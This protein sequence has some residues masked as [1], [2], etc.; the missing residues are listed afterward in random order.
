MRYIYIILLS[1]TLS[2]AIAAVKFGSVSGAF[3]S[4]TNENSAFALGLFI[5]LIA[6]SMELV[7][8]WAS[9]SPFL[10]VH[11]VTKHIEVIVDPDPGG[12]SYIMSNEGKVA[13][14]LFLNFLAFILIFWV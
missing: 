7:D 9:I 1:G 2:F 10:P 14:Y 6:T 4:L 11:L 8:I 5:F 13:L 3:T 12:Q